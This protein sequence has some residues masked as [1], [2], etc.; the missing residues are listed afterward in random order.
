MSPESVPLRMDQADGA[1]RPHDARNKQPPRAPHWVAHRDRRPISP[2]RAGRPSPRCAPNRLSTVGPGGTRPDPD[3]SA[4][5][6]NTSRPNG[7]WCRWSGGRGIRTHE[8]GDTALAVFKI[9]GGEVGRPETRTAARYSN[10]PYR[11]D[12]HETETSRLTSQSTASDLTACTRKI[13]G[14]STSV[15]VHVWSANDRRTPYMAVHTMATPATR[16]STG[17]P[18]CAV[19]DQAVPRPSQAVARPSNAVQ[20]RPVL[21][22]AAHCPR[23][24][25]P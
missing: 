1:S 4:T 5:S 9:A 12:P 2:R 14:S 8:D 6:A 18:R 16:A 19:E 25:Q 15:L 11:T 7:L 21:T 3:E 17:R 13:Q 23:R 24:S 20:R 10:Q 22:H